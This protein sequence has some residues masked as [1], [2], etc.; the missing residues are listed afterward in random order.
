VWAIISPLT[1]DSEPDVEYEKKY[2]GDNMDPLTLSLNTIRGK[3]LHAVMYYAMWVYRNIKEDVWIKEH[4]T[5]SFKDMPEV[6]EVLDQHLDPNVDCS[7]TSRAVYGQWLPQLVHLG[8]EWVTTNITRIFPR[9]PKLKSLRDAVW[10]SYLLYGG[11][12][13]SAVTRTVM[14][15]YRE[16]ALGLKGKQ[17]GDKAYKS[18][19]TRLAEHVVLLYLW[20]EYGLEDNSLIDIF[21]KTA[22]SQLTA[23]AMDFIARD[24]YGAKVPVP[25]ITERMKA[26][27]DWRVKRVGGPNKMSKEEMSAFGWWFASGQFDAAWAFRHLEETL[28]RTGIGR[29]NLQVFER[30]SVLFSGHP[31]EALRCLRLFI[32]RNDDP[33]FFRSPRKKEGA[34]TLLEQA[35]NSTDAAI[36]EK[37][38]EIIHLLGSKGYLEYRE[39]LKAR[40]K[41]KGNA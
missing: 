4:R 2:G 39:L 1:D 41:G 19:E 13:H 33:W 40:Q 20:G 29:S 31:H 5:P 3:A 35:M 17:I 24:T 7:Q 6:L 27:W 25:A 12:I 38:E 9:E 8:P 14:N 11:Q 10:H 30:M 21:F 22:P 15:I 28:K 36:V 26:L 34:R 23:H 32:D 16:E 18:P 37:A